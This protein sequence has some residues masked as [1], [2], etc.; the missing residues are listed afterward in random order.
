MT[1]C[2]SISF[3]EGINQNIPMKIIRS[4]LVSLAVFIVTLEILSRILLLS[5]YRAPLV[6]PRLPFSFY[7]ALGPQLQTPG[8]YRRIAQVLHEIFEEHPELKTPISRD[9]SLADLPGKYPPEAVGTGKPF[10]E[11]NDIA[12]NLDGEYVLKTIETGSEKYRIRYSTDEFRRRMVPGPVHPKMNVFFLGCSFTW[13]EGVIAEKIFVNRVAAAFPE[14]RV[15]N[16]G[17]P[18]ASPASVLKQILNPGNDYFAGIDRTLPT[19]VVFTFV[20][21]H[22]RRVAGSSVYLQRGKDL[23]SD[24][25]WIHLGS[26]NELRIEPS[27]SQ[28]PMHWFY[29]FFG[30]TAFSKVAAIELPSTGDRELDTMAILFR[31]MRMHIGNKFPKL[32]GLTVASYPQA[33]PL[34]PELGLRLAAQA[35]GVLDYSS[36][37]LSAL[38]PGREALPLDPHPS[39]I[40]HEIYARLLI[41]DLK[42][43]L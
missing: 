26:R 3:S 40:A 41:R 30:K 23:I 17:R 16:F 35:I 11:G 5:G 21:D 33:N 18:A 1:P 7:E 20:D 24:G 22:F 8:Q 19:H 13:G 38:I 42:H 6:V 12:P 4:V 9:R 29:L 34:F 36:V 32:Q 25:P 28:D 14:A 15:Y 31:E 39:E 2:L 37:H 10:M 27:F 43:Q